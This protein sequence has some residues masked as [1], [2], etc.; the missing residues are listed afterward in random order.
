[1]LNELVEPAAELPL[2]GRVGGPAV[3]VRVRVPTAGVAGPGRGVRAGVVVPHED[4]HVAGGERRG[5]VQ[6]DVRRLGGEVAEHGGA[7]AGVVEVGDV[8]AGRA[9]EPLGM[10][11][12]PRRPGAA[13]ARAVV[14]ARGPRARDVVA[15]V[16]GARV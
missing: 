12:G 10:A 7:A 14:V 15:V 5:E 13:E 2:E 16:A 11:V 9:L 8:P 4:R 6:L 1:N 3:V